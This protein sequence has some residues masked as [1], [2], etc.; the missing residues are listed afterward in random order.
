MSVKLGV[1]PAYA[2]SKGISADLARGKHGRAS[3]QHR[4]GVVAVVSALTT[5]DGS[6]PDCLRVVTPTGIEPVFQP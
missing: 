1:T 3:D 6:L 4:C 5:N 2:G